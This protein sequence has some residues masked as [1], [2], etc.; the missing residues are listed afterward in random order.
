MIRLCDNTYVKRFEFIY[1]FIMVIYMG[2]MTAETTR[3]IGGLSAPW[4]PFLIPLI[5]TVI[6]VRRNQTVNYS[7]TK[8]IKLLVVCIIWEIAVTFVKGL[9]TISDQSFQFFLF[10]AIV[11]AFI[12]ASVFKKQLL[13]LYES[14]IVIIAK[15]SIVL[16]GLSLLVPSLMSSVASIFPDTNLGHNIAYL[17]NYISRTS[18]HFMRNSGCAWEPGRYAIMLL[19][20][21]YCNLER[22]GVKFK[23]NS[24]VVWILSAL[25]S[26]MSTTGYSIAIVMYFILFIKEVKGSVKILYLLIFIPVTFYLLNLDFMVEKI[27]DQL[28]VQDA[29]ENKMN[30]ISNYYNVE[31][32]DGEYAFSVGRIESVFFEWQSIIHDPIVG[33]GRNPKHSYFAESISSNMS[34]TNGFMKLFGMYGILLASFFYILLY[35]SSKYINKLNGRN[36]STFL[37][38]T[39][40]LSSMSYEVFTIPVF[41]SFWLFELINDNKY[42]TIN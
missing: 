38:W 39:L 14:I 4:I 25:A 16:W 8:F 9:Y 18:E 31:Y 6:L 26:T 42:D 41:T 15:I 7:N 22:N 36:T 24:N 17:Y 33:Y 5:L 12:H 35:R 23:G 30:N 29:V 19:L 32:A 20:G 1:F 40:L 27:T 37:F 28:D 11:I 34:L 3:M 2:Q 13:P 21:L 10:Y